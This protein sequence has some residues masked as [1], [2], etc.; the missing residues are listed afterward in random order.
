VDFK[1]LTATMKQS[2]RQPALIDQIAVANQLGEAVLWHPGE[3]TLWWSDIL[4]RKLHRYDPST[5]VL[6]TWETPDR[7]TAFGFMESDPRLVVSFAS[8]FA[9]FNPVAGIM[10]WLARPEQHLSGNRFNDGRVD[11]RGRFWAGTMVEQGEPKDPAKKA[12]LYCLNPDGSCEKKLEDFLITNALCWSPDGRVMYHADSPTHQIRAYDFDPDTAGITNPRVFAQLESSAEAD[13]AC[14]DAQG[15]LWNAQWGAGRVR[16]YSPDG[17]VLR[18]IEV[19][20]SQVTCVAFGGPQLSWLFVTTARDGL[21]GD[22]LAK[23]PGAG[24]G[25]DHERG[26][27]R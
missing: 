16:C 4:S 17:A 14:T 8:G 9:L 15:N 20:V 10:Q 12:A 6:D 25:R 27:R 21:S 18:Q 3:N 7:L 13:G 22:Q 24:D 1:E 5:K 2:R 23:Q 11:P 19:P 26:G